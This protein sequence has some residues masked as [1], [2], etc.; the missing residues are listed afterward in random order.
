MRTERV[1]FPKRRR[2]PR[3]IIE[4]VGASLVEDLRNLEYFD[5]Q[6]NGFPSYRDWS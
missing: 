6:L 4:G 1:S 5:W 2:V 3:F